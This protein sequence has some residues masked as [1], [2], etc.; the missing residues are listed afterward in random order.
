MIKIITLLVPGFC[1]MILAGCATPHQQI[2]E[3]V[4][5]PKEPNFHLEGE[6]IRDAF[7][8]TKIRVYVATMPWDEG[9]YRY[10]FLRLW[11]SG[12]AFLSYMRLSNP[13]R[14][15]VE[16]IEYGGAGYFTIRNGE[17]KLEIFSRSG[18][19]SYQN[20]YGKI[21]GKTIILRGPWRR[22]TL[23]L[24]TMEALPYHLVDFGTLESDP[25]W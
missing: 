11:P 7:H 1:L 16:A 12:E 8:L 24:G 22:G 14:E 18:G 2:A 25:L 15:D 21:E 20:Y 4:S 13:T 9:E 10:R 5:F 17:I 6:R 19:G 23:Q 3:R